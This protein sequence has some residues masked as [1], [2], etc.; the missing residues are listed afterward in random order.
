MVDKKSFSTG[1]RYLIVSLLIIGLVFRFAHLDKKVYWIDEVNTSIRVSA[2]TSSEIMELVPTGEVIGVKDLQAFQHPHPQRDIRDTIQALTGNAEHSPLYYLMA[3]FWMQW[4]GSS[5]IAM[6]SLPAV[7]SLL[8]FPCLYW[9]CRELFPSPWVGGIAIGLMAISPFHLLYAQEARQYSLWTVTILLSSA[10]LLWAMRNDQPQVNG[11]NL[12][13][14]YTVYPSTNKDLSK[15]K[16]SNLIHTINPKYIGVKWVIYAASISLG[17]YSHL[18][19]LFVILSHG[20]YVL[21]CQILQ[22]QA[23]KYLEVERELVPD[24][25]FYKPI[26]KLLIYSWATLIGIVGFFPWIL[27]LF[28]KSAGMAGWLVRTL[29]I[30]EITQRWL[31]N[32]SSIFFDIQVGYVSPIFSIGSAESGIYLSVDNPF[33]YVIFAIVVI[34]IYAVIT[35]VTTQ[36]PQTWLF[37]LTLIVIPAMALVLPDLISGGQRSVTGRYLIPSYLGIQIAVAYLLRMK[38]FDLKIQSRKLW[39]LLLIAL[40]LGGILSCGVSSQSETWWNKYSSYDYPQVAKVINQAPSPLI[41]SDREKI[42]RLISLS[43]L[44]DDKVSVMVIEPSSLPNIPA[45]FQPVFVFKPMEQWF[46]DIKVKPMMNIELTH[47]IGDLWLV[48]PRIL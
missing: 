39:Q 2:Y 22:I 1:L 6:R 11:I 37:I 18:L 31:I 23:G 29:S 42:G 28:N 26:G 8:T 9:L 10:A 21:I 14:I 4:F 7:I 35:L 44:L 5:V 25:F 3:R 12:R 34:E 13:L 48:Q 20:L 19:F 36:P 15:S 30:T 45:G 41:I 47:Q 16:K 32:L 17:L 43:Y 33:T 46:S 40:I 24:I 27:V 38:L